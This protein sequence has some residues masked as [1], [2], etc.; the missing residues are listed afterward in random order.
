MGINYSRDDRGAV[1]ILDRRITTKSYGKIFLRS[2][3]ETEL[4]RGDS[5]EVFAKMGVFF[6]RDSN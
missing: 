5:D 2:L 4:V 1:L 3:P 6:G